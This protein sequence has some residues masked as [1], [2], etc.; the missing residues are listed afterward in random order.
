MRQR[1]CLTLPSDLL[2]RLNDLAD[3]R[4]LSRSAVA[5][6][7]IASFLSPDALDTREAAFTRRL[8]RLS[9]QTARLERD[10]RLTADT[11]ALFVR[12]WLTITPPLPPEA[13]ATAQ[14]KG[15]ERFEG[16]VQ[17]LAIRLQQ[18]S[19]FLSEI[20]DDIDLG[21]EDADD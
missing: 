15:K 3:R 2:A 6:A 18:G 14:V 12:H 11:L 7:A 19:S 8:D 5:E 1:L 16:F 4:K 21:R 20:P 17:T 10:V 9:R 13:H